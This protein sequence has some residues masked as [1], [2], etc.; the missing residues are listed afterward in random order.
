MN[1][2]GSKIVVCAILFL[3]TLVSG[4]LL[5]SSGRPLN[6]V[7][8]TIHKMIALAAVIV[9]GMNVYQL[10]RLIDARAVL[11]IGV[12]AAAA[13]LFLALFISGA[14]LSLEKPAPGALLTIHQ[15]APLLA[16]FASGL[17]L[18]LL[19]SNSA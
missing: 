12:I 8:F 2:S 4:F 1:Y 15:I 7:L 14:L 3:F 13:L 18:Y 16:L 9:I 17:A 19:A 11:T 5:S 6:G 10:S